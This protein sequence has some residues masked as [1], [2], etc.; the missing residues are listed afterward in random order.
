MKS[1]HSSSTVF[2]RSWN[3]YELL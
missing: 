2:R 1:S 3:T